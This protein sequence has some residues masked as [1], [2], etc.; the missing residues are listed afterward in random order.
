MLYNIKAPDCS[1]ALINQ[2]PTT[3]KTILNYKI[4]SLKPKKQATK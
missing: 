3:M 2:H 1:E 4:I